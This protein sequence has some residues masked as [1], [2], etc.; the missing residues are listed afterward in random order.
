MLISLLKT[1]QVVFD[2][3]KILV[4]FYAF[5]E[6]IQLERKYSINSI[7]RKLIR[8]LF[9]YP[10]FKGRYHVVNLFKP[11]FRL[12]HDPIL[13]ELE[14]NI[15][16]EIDPRKDKGVES[17]LFY[18]GVYE[19]GTL[20]F[21]KKHL[22]EGNTYID[23]G[24][25][26]GLM[27]ITASKCVGEKGVVLAIEPNPETREILSRNIAHNELSNISIL[28][29]AIGSQAGTAIIY[30]NWNINRGGASLI[31]RSTDQSGTPVEVCT[32]DEVVS[33]MNLA[34]DVI[35]I[36]VEG[37]ELE[38]LKGAKS[39]LTQ[40]NPP[41]IILEISQERKTVGGNGEELIDF[42]LNLNQY[43]FFIGKEGKESTGKLVQV[44]HKQEFPNHDNVYCLPKKRPTLR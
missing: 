18:T 2:C 21:L 35:K 7:L 37:F 43:D 4:Y 1:N 20:E 14:D 23:V 6:K 3:Y 32:L 44:E 22:A 41:I 30:P 9:R 10:K 26:I 5:M 19:V 15:R 17:A 24:S 38:V 28:D 39:L 25:N 27:A 42:L 8:S 33:Q 11:L 31:N 12:P 40:T 13:I 29:K 16:I 36:D 34:P